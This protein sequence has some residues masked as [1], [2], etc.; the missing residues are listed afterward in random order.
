M[1]VYL[2]ADLQLP[3]IP[4]TMALAVVALIGYFVGKQSQAR[5]D[6]DEASS[7]HLAQAL[8]DARQLEELTDQMLLATRQALEHC[9]QLTVHSQVRPP[10]VAE[11]LPTVA[12][13]VPA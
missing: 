13:R 11:R 6:S 1:P 5:G 10:H 3:A 8:A 4:A 2:L 12:D 9:R 7:R